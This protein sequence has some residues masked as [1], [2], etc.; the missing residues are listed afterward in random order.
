MNNKLNVLAIDD[1]SMSLLLIKN[2]L[3][4]LVNV[5]TVKS[6]TAAMLTLDNVDKISL[7]L[8]DLDMPDVS[9]FE[10]LDFLSKNP[11][12]EKAPVIIISSNNKIKTIKKVLEYSVVDFVAKPFEA[13]TLREKVSKALGLPYERIEIEENLI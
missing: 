5:Y 9:G 1:F 10:F 6:A 3:K 13:E 11:M 4:D 7:F 12:Y 8:L 2:S